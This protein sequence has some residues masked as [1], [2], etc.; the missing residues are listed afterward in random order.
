MKNTQNLYLK[1]MYLLYI[2]HG[3]I[4]VTDVANKL[5]YSK[6]SVSKALV[7]LNNSGLIIYETYKDIELTD[8][9]KQ[10]AKKIISKEDILEIFFVGVL[11]ISEGQAK[12]DIDIISEYLSDETKDKLKLYIEKSLK[13][14]NN[15]NCCCNKDNDECKKCVTKIVKNRVESNQKWLDILK[16]KK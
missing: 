11:N 1:T 5:G 6:S 14:N 10:I 9:A 4:R 8:D 13:I 12:K 3:K 7:R 15:N 16:E 2:E